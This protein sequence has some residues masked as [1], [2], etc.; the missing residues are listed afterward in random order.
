MGLDFLSDFLVLGTTVSSFYKIRDISIFNDFIFYETLDIPEEDDQENEEYVEGGYLEEDYSEDEDEEYCEDGDLEE[1]YSEDEDEKYLESDDSEDDP[2]GYEWDAYFENNITSEND[3]RFYKILETKN[4]D[5]EDLLEFEDVDFLVGVGEG[6][7]PTLRKSSGSGDYSNENYKTLRDLV[8][9]NSEF[10]SL[11]N[12]KFYLNDDFF[13]EKYDPS[14]YF[15]VILGR[16]SYYTHKFLRSVENTININIFFNKISDMTSTLKFG[17]ETDYLSEIKYYGE[18]GFLESD[19]PAIIFSGS[20]SNFSPSSR[21]A[22]GTFNDIEKVGTSETHVFLY[23]NL[24]DSEYGDYVFSD[25]PQSDTYDE[26]EYATFG[27]EDADLELSLLDFDELDCEDVFDEVDDNV[28]ES[29]NNS[30]H[31]NSNTEAVN[32]GSEFLLSEITPKLHDFEENSD[33]TLD[34]DEYFENDNDYSDSIILTIDSLDGYEDSEDPFWEGEVL[35]FAK[36]EESMV[37]FEDTDSELDEHGLFFEKIIKYLSGEQSEEFLYDFDDMGFEDDFVSEFSL[38]SSEEKL[39]DNSIFFQNDVDSDY[40]D[41][42]E[43]NNDDERE[44]GE[45]IDDLDD[46][47]DYADDG[48]Q[49]ID[50]LDLDPDYD[51]ESDEQ[52]E[53]LEVDDSTPFENEFDF[54]IG[55]EDWDEIESDE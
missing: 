8:S 17:L 9:Q 6:Y 37:I 20:E 16:S 38:L 48:D 24:E 28:L 41:D 44:D 53:D 7:L 13:F 34:F 39:F 1:D 14:S 27:E 35:E 2:F 32:T 19:S 45:L 47:D 40:T 33:S 21:Y 49:G 50:D 22:L 3:P 29:A 26:L 15:E 36:D 54:N 55:E 10:S 42:T 25:F 4:D 5:F 46:S 11:K 23:N 31:N 30:K 12:F 43:N 51:S 52:E 18:Y